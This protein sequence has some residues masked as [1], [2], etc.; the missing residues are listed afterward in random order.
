MVPGKITPGR[1]SIEWLGFDS[2]WRVKLWFSA[3]QAGCYQ[4]EATLNI[5]SVVV[6]ANEHEAGRHTMFG[7]KSI[8]ICYIN[9]YGTF[10]FCRLLHN[11]LGN[12]RNKKKPFL[13][14]TSNPVCVVKERG[15]LDLIKSGQ[16]Q[17]LM[18]RL[19]IWPLHRGPKTPS[20]SHTTEQ[21]TRLLS[22]SDEAY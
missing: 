13:H 12:S 3:C 10:V 20:T 7:G 16:C 15:Q 8:F 21:N 18:R 4:N 17:A 14:A 19:L 5:L 6:S 22:K 9:I 11:I 1:S 2:F